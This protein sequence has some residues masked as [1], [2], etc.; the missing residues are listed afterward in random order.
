M[1][2]TLG[3]V[4]QVAGQIR[5]APACEEAQRNEWVD[6][7]TGAVGRA[8]REYNYNVRCNLALLTFAPIT[9]DRNRSDVQTWRLRWWRLE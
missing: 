7:A 1:A 3:V 5:P 4:V 2:R 6:C 9:S 8:S